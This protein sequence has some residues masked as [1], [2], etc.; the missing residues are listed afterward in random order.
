MGIRG[1]GLK[2]RL[3]VVEE[4]AERDPEAAAKL[5]ELRHASPA[6]YRKRI[7]SLAKKDGRNAPTS[8]TKLDVAPTPGR[9]TDPK[10]RVG[11]GGDDGAADAR[12]VATIRTLEV[13]KAAAAAAPAPVTPP[14]PEPVAEAPKKKKKAKA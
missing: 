7:R 13:E 8:G 14:D 11:P 4:L 3:S 1:T 6:K 2:K 10:L 9:A 5:L 12:A